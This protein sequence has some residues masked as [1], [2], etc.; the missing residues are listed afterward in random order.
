MSWNLFRV[1]EVIEMIW[2]TRYEW[3]VCCNYDGVG[4]VGHVRELLSNGL[5]PGTR[6]C[7][8]YHLCDWRT[9]FNDDPVGTE[10]Y[11]RRDTKVAHG[12]F[13]NVYG[14]SISDTG[15]VWAGIG[16][17]YTIETRIERVDVQLHAMTG[18]YS[19]GTGVDLGGPI[20]FRSGI[21]V[22][23][24]LENGMRL[25]LGWDHRSNLEIYS[26]NP[27]VKMV[28]VRLSIPLE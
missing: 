24:H 16:H 2:F 12:P 7:G 4:T 17:A 3:N 22:A 19:R 5:F 28:H 8:V 1:G 21:E 26:R 25:G 18:L 10:V 9:S 15:D 20:E 13:Q 6:G 14:L 27:G 11:V 23:Y